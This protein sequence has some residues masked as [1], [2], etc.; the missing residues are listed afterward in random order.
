MNVVD[1]GERGFGLRGIMGAEDGRPCGIYIKG[2]SLTVYHLHSL[3]FQHFGGIDTIAVGGAGL[4]P[5]HLYHMKQRGVLHTVGRIKILAAFFI[6]II[7]AVVG[8]QF[9]PS[10]RGLA[11]HPHKGSFGF[12]HILQIRSVINA[13]AVGRMSGHRQADKADETENSLCKV[14]E[15]SFHVVINH[16]LRFVSSWGWCSI[17]P[18]GWANSADKDRKNGL[19]VCVTAG[20][21]RWATR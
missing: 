5:G 12:F 1:D 20:F 3:V 19:P 2:G 10:Y 8:G 16:S 11:S 21:P 13:D 18:D 9:H 17:V 6:V 7:A 14:R 15:E 4:K